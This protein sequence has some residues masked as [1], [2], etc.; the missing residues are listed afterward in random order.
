[1]TF[2]GLCLRYL[3]I[4]DP[5]RDGLDPHSLRQ[6]GN[7]LLLFVVYVAEDLLQRI[8]DDG[9]HFKSNYLQ[10]LHLVTSTTTD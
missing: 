1:M 10:V 9:G 2:C 4:L 5:G 8:W 3:S 6:V 7:E